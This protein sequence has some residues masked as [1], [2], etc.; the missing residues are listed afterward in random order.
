M[1]KGVLIF[2]FCTKNS[3]INYLDIAS[4]SSRLVKKF[5]RLP[6]TVVTNVK[7]EKIPYVD[8]IINVENDTHQIRTMNGYNKTF[9][10][11]WN[12]SNRFDAYKLSP[13]NQT[14]LIDADYLIFD[15][16]LLKLF[17][18]NLEFACF[19]TAHDIT[20]SGRLEGDST[21]G[22]NSIN[23]Q[24]A[25]AIYF[26]KSK[27][28]ES[29]FS[30]MEIINK[31]YFYYSQLYNF[32]NNLYRNDFSLSIA[33]QACTGYSNKNFNKIPGKL[34][35]ASTDV[36]ITEIRSINGNI[37]IIFEWVNQNQKKITKINNA[38]IHIMNKDLFM[39]NNFKS[40]IGKIHAES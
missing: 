22:E 34:L 35:T 32:K 6:I 15:N 37:E 11:N 28:S 1:S 27:L 26:T 38:S 10:I 9:D 23:M 12:N 21:V 39:D 17:D 2:A 24:W 31:N 33:L 20:N 36:T 30:M 4:I 14:L 18:S 19:D 5:L 29:I 8:N 13:Y 16:T 25:T 7:I 40:M 3:K